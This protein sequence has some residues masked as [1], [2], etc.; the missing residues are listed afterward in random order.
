ML[1]I[2]KCEKR[3]C[4]FLKSDDIVAF[5][6]IYWDNDLALV[7]KGYKAPANFLSKDNLSF[8][9]PGHSKYQRMVVIRSVH[10]WII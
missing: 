3:D 5:V 10:G 1:P 7:V 4:F 8:S 6:G 2:I 9:V